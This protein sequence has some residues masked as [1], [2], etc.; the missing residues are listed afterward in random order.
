MWRK[1]RGSKREREWRGGKVEDWR[2][3]LVWAMR[4]GGQELVW[5]RS[6]SKVSVEE[7]WTLGPSS[8]LS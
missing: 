6:G 8:R 2:R 1:E 3:V 4:G 7:D 5:R